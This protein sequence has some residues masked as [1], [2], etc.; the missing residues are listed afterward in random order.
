[1]CSAVWAS[2]VLLIGAAPAQAQA[3]A[4]TQP[5]NVDCDE[6]IA[7]ELQSK[8]TPYTFQDVLN[9]NPKFIADII[10]DDKTLFTVTCD[11]VRKRR[12]AGILLSLGVKDQVYFDYLADGAK[13]ALKNDMPWPM[14]YDENGDVIEKATPAYL[15]WCKKFGLDPNDPKVAPLK[16][17]NSAFLEWC[18]KH[19]VHPSEAMHDV[20]YEIPD[21]WDDLAAASDPRFY[22]LL[23]EGLHSHNLI[24]AGIAARGLARLQDPRAI[25]DLIATGRRVGSE[26]R[27]YIGVSL[28]YFSDPK[29]Q[30][31]AEELIRDKSRLAMERK[32]MQTRGLKGLF[33]Y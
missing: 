18:I 1:V 22:D 27:Y 14:V 8:K 2:V 20:Y 24:I 15:E 13:E 16:G 3:A 6:K 17:V 5:R 7:Q 32:E 21:P 31:A 19:E 23:I 30:A 33:P 25:D 12:I 28:L 11:P 29:A 10:S 26:A 9:R 4:S